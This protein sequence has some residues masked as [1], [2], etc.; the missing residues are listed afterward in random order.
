MR[1]Y[2][3]QCRADQCVLRSYVVDKNAVLIFEVHTM[4]ESGESPTS[5]DVDSTSYSMTDMMST[6]L[7]FDIL[8]TVLLS[9]RRWAAKP[10]LNRLWVALQHLSNYRVTA[11]IKSWGNGRNLM[12]AGLLAKIILTTGNIANWLES[13]AMAASKRVLHSEAAHSTNNA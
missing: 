9:S 2:L 4:G 5:L 1:H 7:R 12:V 13:E 6:H 10:C 3:D 8:R 11:R